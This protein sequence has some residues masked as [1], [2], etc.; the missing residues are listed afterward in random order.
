MNRFLWGLVVG[1]VAVPVLVIVYLLS[2]YAPTAVTDR[3]I[4]LERFL[5][6]GALH[7]RTHREAPKRDLASFTTPDLVAG[8]QVFRRSC[9]CHGLPQSTEQ[10][11]RP[12]TFPPAPQLF[13]PDGSVAD[14]PVGVNYWKVKN[15]IRLTG[16]P[17][18]K[19][20]LSD[21]QMWQ[22]AALVANADKLPTEALDALKQPFFMPPPPPAAGA[23][24]ST[25][26]TAPGNQVKP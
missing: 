18:F 2:G 19:L 3:P 26:A 5:A 15:G 23:P 20:V 9:G 4:P 14:D 21:E 12:A 8:A 17:S 16:M 10:H 25:P 22:V 24:A 11:A 7:A 6:A 1:M 13:T